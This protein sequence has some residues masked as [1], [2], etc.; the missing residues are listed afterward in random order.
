[1]ISAEELKKLALACESDGTFLIVDEIYGDLTFQER[2]S[3]YRYDRIRSVHR[4][5]I[6]GYWG[7][8]DSD[9]L[10]RKQER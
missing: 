7:A 6:Q 4:I 3:M 1:M 2:L 9:R 5:I 8:R 10:D